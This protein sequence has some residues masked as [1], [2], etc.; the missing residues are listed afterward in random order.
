[1]DVGAAAESAPSFLEPQF[2]ALL[3]LGVEEIDLDLALDPLEKVRQMTYRLSYPPA[4]GS[5]PVKLSV[6][7]DF[8][9]FGLDGELTAPKET[10]VLDYSD[11]LSR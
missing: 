8:L 5:K 6:T 7:V 1:V 3:D 10:R 2:Q 4:P 9:K 11:Y